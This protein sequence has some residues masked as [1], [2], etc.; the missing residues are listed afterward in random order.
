M[1]N[2]ITLSFIVLSVITL[3][4]I[5]LSVIMISVM[6]LSFN[7]Q[8]VIILSVII[9]SVIISFMMLSVII[10]SVIMMSVIAPYQEWPVQV[11]L[12]VP[13]HDV[14]LHLS[15]CYKTFSAHSEAKY[16]R[17][18]SATMRIGLKGLQEVPTL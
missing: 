10:L 5:I 12:V 1:L 8:N 16:A 6:L 15:T 18:F 9:L 4:V 3:S 2:V 13:D 11:H 14:S 7:I 17:P